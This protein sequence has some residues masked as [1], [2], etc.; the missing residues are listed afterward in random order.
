MKSLVLLAPVLPG[1]LCHIGVDREAEAWVTRELTTESVE[2]VEGLKPGPWHEEYVVIAESVAQLRQHLPLFTEEGVAKKLTVVLTRSEAGYLRA[3]HKLERA[4]AWRPLMRDEKP[5]EYLCYLTTDNWTSIHRLLI[6]VL[7][8]SQTPGSLVLAGTRLGVTDARGASWA[9][10]DT[11]ARLNRDSGSVVDS[12]DV[13]MGRDLI[14][15]ASHHT[16]G[17]IRPIRDFRNELPPVDCAV[18]SPQGFNPFPQKGSVSL[19]P[20]RGTN[21]WRL[22]APDQGPSQDIAELSENT[23]HAIRDYAIVE[24]M[25]HTPE[26]TFEYA[27]LLSQ[28]AVAGVPVKVPRLSYEVETLLGPKIS[29][30]LQQY[31]MTSTRDSREQASINCRREAIKQFSPR[32]RWREFTLGAVGGTEEKI[33]VVLA[34]NR[35]ELL[36]RVMGQLERQTLGDFEVVIGLHGLNSL[37]PV[38]HRILEQFRTPVT[39]EHVPAEWSLGAVLNRLSGICSGELIAKIDDD[40]WYSPHHL[41]DLLLAREYSSAALVGAPVEFTYVEALDITTRRN[42]LSECFTDHVAGGTMLISKSDLLQVGGWRNVRSAVDRALI[43]AVLASGLSV[44]RTHGQNYLM[45]RRVNTSELAAH[46][47]KADE[48]VFVKNVVQQWD[49]FRFPAQFT[50]A[51]YPRLDFTRD[52]QYL[53]YFTEVD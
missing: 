25:P 4:N 23:L 31:S 24:V 16:C 52:R 7:G 3:S 29:A 51:S 1:L 8:I 34:T 40:D 53:S 13:S 19:V 22:V 26:N 27:R 2:L 10:G 43:D 47:W 50:R 28:L 41:E 9:A 37:E 38:Q 49:G 11:L 18:V 46:T 33:S 36:T 20:V 30:A 44:Y 45:H 39:V 32:R 5:E 21:R 6:A 48:S 35:P 12:V 42:F 15:V 17:I 14:P